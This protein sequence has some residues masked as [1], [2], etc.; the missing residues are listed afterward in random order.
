MISKLSV[1]LT[2]Y[3]MRKGLITEADEELYI[4]GA[5][6]LLS[7]LVFFAINC[8]IG[9]VL[10]C[11]I[12]SIVFFIAFQFLRAFAGGYHAKT[13]MRCDLMSTFSI[14]ICIIVIKLMS[15]YDWDLPIL[16]L[17]LVSAVV[18]FFLCPLDTPEKPLTGKE[19]VHFRKVSRLIL[20]IILA[21]VILSFVFGLKLLFAPACLSLILECILLSA[22]MIKKLCQKHRLCE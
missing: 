11:L 8:V 18:I 10:S 19:F 22:G 15:I 4:Y 13:E 14:L 5:F 7:H 3:L 17:S 21:L 6:M 1:K 9:A 12:Q 2:H 16:S 20:L